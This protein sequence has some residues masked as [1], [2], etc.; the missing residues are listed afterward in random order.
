MLVTAGALTAKQLEWALDQQKKN[1][2]RLGEILLEAGLSS[3]DD[4]AEARALQ[5]EMP[6]VDLEELTIPGDVINLVPETIGRTYNVV[7]IDAGGDRLAIATANPMDVEAIDAVQRYSKRRVEPLLASTSKVQRMLDR[8]YGTSS[9]E[10]ITASI[11]QAV[12]G[13]DVQVTEAD[14]SDD[15]AEERRQSGQAPVVK[16]VN[17]V[18]QEAVRQHASDIHF[19]PRAG[20]ME[21]RYRI[22]GSLQHIRNLPRQIQAAVT[23][24]I[25][26]MAEL[27]I[28]EKRKPH[29]GRIAV[30]IH[31]KNVD[32]RI[33]TLP[34]QYGERVVIRVLDKSAGQVTIDKLGFGE[35]E[36]AQFTEL[37]S[38]PH[39]IILVT[40][41][42]G[43]GKTTTL[44]SAL[45]HIK[46]PET[47]IMT[48]E[49]PIEYELEGVNQS[50][51]NPKAGLTFP[52]QLRAILRQDPDV[53]LVGEIRD[54]ET[55]TIAFQAAMTGHLVLSTLHC[56]DAPS[57]VTRLTDMGVEPFLIGSSVIGVLAQ[58]LV[59][60]LCPRCKSSY[61]AGPEELIS[62]GL[63]N[64]GEGEAPAEPPQK[65]ELYKPLGCSQ[66]DK[67]GYSGRMAVFEL[68]PVT[69]EMRRL[70][71]E[72]PTADQVRE[73]ALAAGMKTMREH[74][75]EKILAGL[76]T[77]DEARR[78]VFIEE[79]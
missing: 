69:D 34:V 52:V 70:T 66:C 41:P 38:K 39:G 63:R 67:R 62:M 59:K 19:E 51:V 47:N 45:M 37:L 77:L 26:I 22:D 76:T 16:T 30:K 48:C 55:A 10:D 36:F 53:I 5:M 29:D 25:K 75:N 57:A 73:L 42:T 35:R 28:S 65:L 18:L 3:D 43:S 74:A 9:G 1:Y 40:G 8:V 7:P 61:E 60:L 46:S 31:N 12:G 54:K 71:I 2:K 64:H 21:V 58:R 17:L 56:N 4:I 78:R 20:C 68:M 15:I 24:R 6:Y 72:K 27:D 13:V 14:I 23:S 44:Y 49:D 33:S 50:A 79:E 32:L 11:E